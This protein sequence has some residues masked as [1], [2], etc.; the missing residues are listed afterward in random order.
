M[1]I[2]VN[3]ET[4]ETL[5]L[6]PEGKWEKAP[7]AQ[8][9]KTG[10]SVAF[11]GKE[12]T[13]LGGPKNTAMGAAQ[14][15]AGGLARGTLGMASMLANPMGAGIGM[16]RPDTANP[17]SVGT[18]QD[19]IEQATGEWHKPQ[20]SL[21]ELAAKTGEFTPG[22]FAGGGNL[23]KQALTNTLMPAAGGQIGKEAFRGT[24][25]EGLGEFGGEIAGGVAGSGLTAGI[26]K[27]ST[28]K[29][30]PERMG[31]VNALEA[32][33]IKPTAGQ[34]TGDKNLL[35][36]EA[37]RGGA[38]FEGAVDAQRSQLTRAAAKKAGLDAD[39]LTPEV[40]DTYLDDIGS[41]FDDMAANSKATITRNDS[42]KAMQ[43]AE[44]Y[45]VNTEGTAAQNVE[46]IAKSFATDGRKEL[47][48]ETYKALRT[49]IDE[50]ARSA[51]SA[52]QKKALGDLRALLD[53]T[54]E[55]SVSPN[56]KGEWRELRRKYK[57]WLALEK[58]VDPTTGYVTPASL[59]RSA[60]N[61]S[62][63]RTY[64]R[65]NS[66]YTDLGN[67]ADL[68]LER[69]NTSGTAENLRAIMSRYG[70]SAGTGAAIGTYLGGP[71]VAAAGG[72]I[73]GAAPYAADKMLMAKWNQARIRNQMAVDP[74][75][76]ELPGWALP[77]LPQL[78]EGN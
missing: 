27:L 7:T 15:Y 49:Q 3:P 19:L 21:E 43:I 9:P 68:I 60:V 46:Q 20:G 16:V 14:S 61:V 22:M 58:A 75:Y 5:F 29:V 76:W 47:T 2:A 18:Q 10:E 30:S 42:I 31:A 55:S 59:Q 12:W 17:S 25:Y 51:S 69:P 48:G 54:V 33:G 6:S 26:N 73:G 65:G 36:K 63:K 1:P 41:N 45:K 64:L 23:A 77:M 37:Q 4:G 67:A 28:R 11:D 71:L 78:T 39:R 34:A 56:I 35:R 44:K 24:P 62:G 57:N 32:A 72:A 52:N 53:D 38:A 40:V 74:R 8:N 50:A 13:A 70:G 66:D